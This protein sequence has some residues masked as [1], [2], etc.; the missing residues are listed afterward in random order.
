MYNIKSPPHV[1]F[2]LCVRGNFYTHSVIFHFTKYCIYDFQKTSKFMLD[3]PQNL[4]VII[5]SFVNFTP[6][7]CVSECRYHDILYVKHLIGH[8]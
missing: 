2:S 5:C 8:Y 7:I 1:L 4:N 3:V 6:N